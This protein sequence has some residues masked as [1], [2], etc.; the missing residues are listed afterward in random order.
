MRF[1][2]CLAALLLVAAPALA[3]DVPSLLG[4]WSG[5]QEG[6]GARD[7]FKKGPVTLIVGEQQ[8]RAFTGKVIY[9]QG[10][11]EG[12]SPFYGSI[13]TDGRMVSIADE[14]G[15]AFGTVEGDTLQ[16]CYVETGADA[17]SACVELTRQK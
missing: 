1:L 5:E 3:A 10:A 17:A 7:G 13:A 16:L 8:G 15:A 2:S 9:P 12:S 6:A 11:G 4:T 14:D